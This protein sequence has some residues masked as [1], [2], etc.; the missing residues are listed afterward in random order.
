MLTRA[1]EEGDYV[2]IDLELVGPLGYHWPEDFP[3]LK[4]WDSN[5]L[6]EVGSDTVS[7]S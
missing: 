3:L 7:L 5:T 1:G 6:H 4:D 2:V